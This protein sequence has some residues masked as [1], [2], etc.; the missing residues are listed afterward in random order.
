MG[1]EVR[2]VG[3]RAVLVFDQ[4]GPAL[5]L[6]TAADFLGEAFSASAD[7]IVA[8]VQRLDP[9]FFHLSSRIAGEVLQKFVNYGIG[10]AV[11]GEIPAEA[12][13][14]QALADFVRE[15]NRGRSVWFVADVDEALARLAHGG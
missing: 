7:W 11:A 4:D 12:A 5:G 8:P 1:S 14:S 15:S 2:Q 13:R 3:G 10:V 9:A 6:A